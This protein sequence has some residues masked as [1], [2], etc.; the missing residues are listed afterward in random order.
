MPETIGSAFAVGLALASRHRAIAEAE[1]VASVADRLQT[2][3]AR[4]ATLALE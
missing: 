3:S 4:K 2:Y 1:A